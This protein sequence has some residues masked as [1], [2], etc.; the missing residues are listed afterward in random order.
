MSE[1]IHPAI[2]FQ[3]M[4]LP[5]SQALRRSLRVFGRPR[6]LLACRCS[7]VDCFF[8]D[9]IKTANTVEAQRL[10]FFEFYLSNTIIA[11]MFIFRQKTCIDLTFDLAQAARH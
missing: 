3:G 1:I 6:G 5:G 10:E 7:H 11:D 8:M 4:D 2:F 9:I